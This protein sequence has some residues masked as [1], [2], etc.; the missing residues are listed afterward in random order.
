MRQAKTGELER[1]ARLGAQ[2]R[3]VRDHGI[4]PGEVGDLLA[5]RLGRL[6]AEQERRPAQTER[7]TEDKLRRELADALVAS[8]H[9]VWFQE[10]KRADADAIDARWAPE[11]GRAKREAG[12]LAGELS[13]DRVRARIGRERDAAFEAARYRAGQLL[14]RTLGDDGG[15]VRDP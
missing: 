12:Q 6:I 2:F 9:E 8:V 3:P 10:L 1:A 11:V 14:R 5:A 4:K 13:A 7:E 15:Q